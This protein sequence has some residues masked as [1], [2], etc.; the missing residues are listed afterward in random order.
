MS[1]RTTVLATCLAAGF[2]VGCMHDKGSSASTSS[3]NGPSMSNGNGSSPDTGKPLEGNPGATTNQASG[4]PQSDPGAYH[5][6]TDDTKQYHP[7]DPAAIQPT[8]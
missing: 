1:I 5:P 4:Y 2:S 8:K 3:G 6:Q 7:A